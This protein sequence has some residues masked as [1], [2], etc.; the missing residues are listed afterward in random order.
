MLVMSNLEVVKTGAFQSTS[1]SAE[2]HL[3]MA[4]VA[5]SDL[6]LFLK[7]Q[8]DEG[9]SIIGLEQTSKSVSLTNFKV[10]KKCC[11]LLGTEAFGIPANLFDLLDFVVEIPQ[12]GLVRSLNVHVSGSLL[13][14][15]YARQHFKYD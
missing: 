14:W 7:K 1:V 9:Y 10:P 12:S 3:P 2:K 13:L 11:L 6:P 4:Q 5:I 8:K 15:E